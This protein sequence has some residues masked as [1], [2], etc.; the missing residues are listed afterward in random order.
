MKKLPTTAEL[1][2]SD[3]PYLRGISVE[4]RHYIERLLAQIVPYLSALD[5]LEVT[6]GTP[7][8]WIAGP[9]PPRL[10]SAP[11]TQ[12]GHL[13]CKTDD[14]KYYA[15]WLR[16]D[17]IFFTY[18]DLGGST[19]LDVDA[20]SW[21]QFPFNDVVAGLQNIARKIHKAQSAFEK[22]ET[23]EAQTFRRIRDFLDTHCWQQSF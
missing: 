23:E 11:S 17:G 10:S 6:Q 12:Y 9:Y 4:M 5:V 20:A 7:P 15:L 19:R 13:I 22:T 16:V 1:E 8:V 14:E 3:N 21:R 2:R 18:S